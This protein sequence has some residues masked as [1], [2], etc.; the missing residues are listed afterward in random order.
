MSNISRT[1]VSVSEVNT[2][3]LNANEAHIA[4]I[5]LDNVE[6]L[7]AKEAFIENLTI[8]ELTVLDEEVTGST[9]TSETFE[10]AIFNEVILNFSDE[11]NCKYTVADDSILEASDDCKLLNISLKLSD[12]L[13]SKFV[14]RYL[15]LD[16]RKEST[17]TVIATVWDNADSVKWLYGMPDIQAGYFY[18]IAFQRFAKDLIIGNI[19]IKLSA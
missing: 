4:K 13:G 5:S 12:D 17:D 1:T 19:S 7:Q 6:N 3:I 10:N 14:C 18:V 16:L 2:P 15:V 8:K 11:Y 9:N